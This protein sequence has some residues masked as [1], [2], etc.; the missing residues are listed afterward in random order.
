MPNR[1]RLKLSKVVLNSPGGQLNT[2]GQFVARNLYKGQKFHYLVQVVKGTTTSLLGWGPCVSLGLKGDH[3]KIVLKENA[4]RV[5]I[6]LMSK[7]KAELERMERKG[8]LSSILEP[9]E[10]CIP[11]VPAIKKLGD[12]RI[13]VDLKHLNESIVQ[14]K[15]VIPRRKIF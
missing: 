6:P 12:V 5:Q 1:P 8:V 15:F 3:V 10:W 7:V 14:P 2:L 4:R 11:M 13:C 9:T